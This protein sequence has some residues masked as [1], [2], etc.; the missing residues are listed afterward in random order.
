MDPKTYL[1]E[2]KSRLVASTAVVSIEVMEEYILPD[3]G[4][5]RA[6]LELINN[7]CGHRQ[8]GCGGADLVPV[9]RDAPR[10]VTYSRY[11]RRKLSCSMSDSVMHRNL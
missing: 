10:A 9:H 2:I 5:S 3:R 1:I 11:S 6:R 7:R 4:Y 8:P